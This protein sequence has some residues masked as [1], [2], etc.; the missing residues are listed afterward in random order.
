MKYQDQINIL[1]RLG[2]QPFDQKLHDSGCSPLHAQNIDIFQVNLGNQCNQAC[3]HCHVNAEI[4]KSDMMDKQVMEQC[5]DVLK[6]TPIP[7]VDITG[8]A[9]EMNKHFR[10]FV[11]EC[12]NLGKHVM[13]RSNLTIFSYREI[14]HQL[15]E[16]YSKHGVEII[17]SLPFYNASRTN[18]MRG[19][20]VFEAS[21]KAIQQLNELGYAKEGS[22]KTLTLVYNP[23]G[24]F[25]PGKQEDLEKKYKE[26]LKHEHGVYFNNLFTI[27]NMPIGR[28]LEFLIRSGNLSEYMQDL[29]NAFNPSA[30]PG[31][32]CRN[33][34]SVR[35]DGYMYDCDFNQM[36]NMKVKVDK[37]NHISSFDMNTLA[38]RKIA[39]ARHCYGCTAGSGS[40]CGGETVS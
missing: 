24:A 23:A 2:I 6:N 22:N 11:D 26:A 39:T 12:K 33:T 13:V 16:F 38:H 9:P 18:R 31:V 40:S 35:W 5:L 3:K 14:Y 25:L 8:G 29:D 7:T 4:T 1:E 17:S 21:I 15:P 32:M 19:D 28:F 27:T 10:W 37:A 30:V 34:L 36:L 20:G